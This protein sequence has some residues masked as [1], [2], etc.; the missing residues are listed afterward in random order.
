MSTTVPLKFGND[1]GFRS[2]SGTD[3]NRNGQSNSID[4][5][6]F[7]AALGR[8]A[9]FPLDG[10][11][12]SLLSGTQQA[13]SEIPEDK[14]PADHGKIE[15][16]TKEAEGQIV[17]C[18]CPFA[19]PAAQLLPLGSL[20][21]SDA[22]VP[23]AQ[24]ERSAQVNLTHSMGQPF[25]SDGRFDIRPPGAI[26]PDQKDSVIKA[27]SSMD[28]KPCEDLFASA[29]SNEGPVVELMTPVSLATPAGADAKAIRSSD[30]TESS[31][32]DNLAPSAA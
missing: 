19:L 29:G 30:K 13:A 32:S 24:T 8:L 31:N 7:D 10:G 14:R 28:L 1:A 16:K 25:F 26:L 22:E 12:K 17:I 9:G 2:P 21:G 20:A 5:E 3:A 23:S 6:S 18:D 27:T 4:T 15:A 11:G